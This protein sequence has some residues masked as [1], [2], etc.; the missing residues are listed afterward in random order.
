M[1]ETGI[2]TDDC[3]LFDENMKQ[4]MMMWQMQQMTLP[5]FCCPYNYWT[6][7]KGI[8]SWRSIFHRKLSYIRI[9]YLFDSDF[10]VKLMNE[11]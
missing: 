9:L 10:F 3:F 7:E 4:F 8:D 1:K 2:Q 5:F 11:L 6:A